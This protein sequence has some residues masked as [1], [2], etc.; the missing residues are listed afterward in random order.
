MRL[1]D[2]IAPSRYRHLLAIHILLLCAG[3][4]ATL[5][6]P[7]QTKVSRETVRLELKA[8]SH[9]WKGAKIKG[10]D[11]GPQLATRLARI[12]L[13]IEYRRPDELILFADELG[14]DLLRR[15]ASELMLKGAQLEVRVPCKNQ[16]KRRLS[17]IY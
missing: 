2:V 15:S 8:A 16:W 9:V 6:A 10:G 5:V 13:L 12:R 4:A 1:C 14:I 3:L 11:D 7:T 17:E